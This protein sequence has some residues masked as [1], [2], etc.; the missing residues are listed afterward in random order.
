M[1]FCVYC[2]TPLAFCSMTLV[3][4]CLILHFPIKSI[5]QH[6]VRFLSVYFAFSVHTLCW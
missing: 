4:L 3:H 5:L 6:C 2:V 1:C